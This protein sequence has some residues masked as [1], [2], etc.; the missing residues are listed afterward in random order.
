MKHPALLATGK[1]ASQYHRC[2]REKRERE[3]K[4]KS[5]PLRKGELE[6]SPA[7][8]V[9]GSPACLLG[10]GRRKKAPEAAEP[11]TLRHPDPDSDARRQL[12]KLALHE[13][14][15]GS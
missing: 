12:L 10:L 4:G 2:H 14:F 11:G 8:L 6:G 1:M 7:W 15:N 13:Q 9:E 3:R 5:D